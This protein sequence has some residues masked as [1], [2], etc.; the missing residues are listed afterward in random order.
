[1]P[2]FCPEDRSPQYPSDACRT[3]NDNCRECCPDLGVGPEACEPMLEY[4]EYKIKALACLVTTLDL[5]DPCVLAKF[6]R[7]LIEALA[8]LLLNI[9]NNICALWAEIAKLWRAIRCLVEAL[10]ALMKPRQV[11]FR[12][13]RNSRYNDAGA[14]YKEWTSEYEIGIYMDSEQGVETGIANPTDDGKRELA[15]QDYMVTVDACLDGTNMT[16][17]D[18]I[19]VI[20]LLSSSEE[21]NHDVSIQRSLHYEAG[22]SEQAVPMSRTFILKKGDYI[23]VHLWGDPGG[24][25]GKFRF[26]QVRIMYQDFA[27]RKLPPCVDELEK[28]GW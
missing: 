26:H 13:L 18:N 28:L 5:C 21:F 7:R 15:D 11:R 4:N 3:C 24:A 6:L 8:C 20:T 1:M 19:Q 14:F 2:A 23:K 12:Y 16:S 27:N 22:T 17:T 9:I 10:R 25:G